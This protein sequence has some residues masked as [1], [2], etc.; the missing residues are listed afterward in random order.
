VAI[1]TTIRLRSADAHEPAHRFDYRGRHRYIVT[2]PAR[3]RS[4]PFQD[5]A[6][7]LRVRDALRDSSIQ[8]KFEV[9][10]YCFLP[11]RLVM[12][13][14]GK[15]DSSDMKRFL[16]GFRQVSGQ[17]AGQEGGHRLWSRKFLE[18]VLR[19]SEENRDVARMIFDLP[20]KEGLARPG[21]VYPHMGSFVIMKERRGR[22]PSARRDRFGASR[23]KGSR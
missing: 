12:L 16:T 20:A 4:T 6:A 13:V 3:G 7:V 10:A 5:G 18:R 21:E 1:P 2:L 14:R 11:S 9:Y 15:E 22:D 17:P 23:R 19:K 8:H